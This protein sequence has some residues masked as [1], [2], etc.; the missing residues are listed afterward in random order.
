MQT[1]HIIAGLGWDPAI[2][3]IL[4]VLTGVVVLMGSVWLLLAT[5]TGARLGMLLSLAGLAG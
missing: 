3:G 1:L 4:S 2:R 5:N